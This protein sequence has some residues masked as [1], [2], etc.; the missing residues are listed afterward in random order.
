MHDPGVLVL[1]LVNLLAGLG[2]AVPLARFLRDSGF[3]PA[4]FVRAFAILVGI[5]F[6]EGVAVAMG[7]GIPVLSAGLAFVWGIVFGLWLRNRGSPREVLRTALLLSLYSS[8]PAASFLSVPVL[9]GLGGMHILSTRAAAEFGIPAEPPFFWPL[10]TILGFYA[11]LAIGAVVFKAIV[12]T[13]EVSLLIHLG[14][15]PAPDDA[16]E[17]D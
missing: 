1:L 17:S 11:A 10:N 5:Y 3:G 7:M 15:A 2:C 16:E 13:G 9:A 6:A 14:E 12:T 8:L 4:A